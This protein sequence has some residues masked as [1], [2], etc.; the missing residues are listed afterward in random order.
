MD[1]KMGEREIHAVSLVHELFINAMEEAH[2]HKKNCNGAL[3]RKTT[4]DCVIINDNSNDSRRR[5]L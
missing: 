3:I 5:N 2:K 1:Q 4:T